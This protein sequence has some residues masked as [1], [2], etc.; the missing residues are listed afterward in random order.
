MTDNMAIAFIRLINVLD[1]QLQLDIDLGVSISKATIVLIAEKQKMER[2]L[3]NDGFRIAER[4]DFIKG[5]KLFC[6][7]TGFIK[8]LSSAIS[9]SKMWKTVGSNTY[10][11]ED[12]APHFLIRGN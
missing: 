8:Q 3:E 7:H 1:E 2:A 11:I 4:S 9:G 12:D 10:V 6:R 5:A